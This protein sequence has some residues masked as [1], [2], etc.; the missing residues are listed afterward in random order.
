MRL[1]GYSDK[2][3]F[4]TFDASPQTIWSHRINPFHPVLFDEA[5]V[6]LSIAGER[7]QSADVHAWTCPGKGAF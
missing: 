5:P 3:E 7:V 1:V 4:R 6:T 2:K